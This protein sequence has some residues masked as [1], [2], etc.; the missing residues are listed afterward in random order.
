LEAVAGNLLKSG[1]ATRLAGT[2]APVLHA[3]SAQ[4]V[5][6]TGP[7][8]AAKTPSVALL[9]AFLAAKEAER[10]VALAHEVL[11][12]YTARVHLDRQLFPRS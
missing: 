1:T 12:T 10:A 5:G 7:P 6:S 9:P 4:V 3:G 8:A 11:A 2:R